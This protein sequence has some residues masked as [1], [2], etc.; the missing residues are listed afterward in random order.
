MAEQPQSAAASRLQRL[1]G[2]LAGDPNNARLLADA[3][4]AAL[5]SGDFDQAWALLERACAVEPQNS[6]LHHRLCQVLLARGDYE[7]AH[8]RLLGLLR[9]QPASPALQYDLAYAEVG[10]ERMSDALGT[11]RA[12]AEESRRL[13]P[14]YSLLLARVLYFTGQ[15]E[16]ALQP[17]QA[18]LRQGGASPA[19]AGFCSLVLFD[20]GDVD[21]AR[22]LAQLALTTNAKD[23]FADL[24][25]GSIAVA[26]QQPEEA[27][28]HLTAVAQVRPSWGRV[29]SALGYMEL[30]NVQL[31]KARINFQ[32]AVSLMPEHL[33]TWH[34]LAW[35]ELLLGDY[36]AS[37]V[38]IARAMDVDR[39]FSEN[40]GT[41]AVL[42]IQDGRPEL[43]E[44]EIKRGLRLNPKSPSSHY[45][46]SLLLAQKGDKA[47]SEKLVRRILEEAGLLD[48]KQIG[49]LLARAK[50]GQTGVSP[51]PP[52]A[53]KH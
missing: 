23:V 36:A 15:A 1:L 10:C 46:R 27:A 11:L 7:G 48:G 52:N 53:R 5:E 30:L 39:T 37:R 49:A 24:V 17:V 3:G 14:H 51:P 9:E 2:F 33:G 6:A 38:S 4:D 43:A 19:Q 16:A 12:I 22:R 35:T 50:A 18:H 34:G 31:E 45:A 32:R 47:A 28:P 29:W 25:L 41:L 20:N 26:R 44:A 8:T 40:H 13:L 21:A 42:E